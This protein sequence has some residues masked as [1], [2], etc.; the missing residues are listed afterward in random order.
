MRKIVKYEKCGFVRVS[1]DHNDEDEDEDDNEDD[2][3]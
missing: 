1:A 2:D 3:E